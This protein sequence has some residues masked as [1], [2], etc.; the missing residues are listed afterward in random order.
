MSNA[1]FTMEA[2]HRHGQG[3]GSHGRRAA[4][5]GH[6]VLEAL[7]D[8]P[9]VAVVDIEA[10]TGATRPAANNLLARLTALGIL[11]QVT[12]NARRRR[13]RDEPYVRLF[14]GKTPDDGT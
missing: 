10:A 5:N 6:E 1:A 11:Q 8:R 7:F 13:F 14:S 4:G 3:N 12:G 2:I 9:I